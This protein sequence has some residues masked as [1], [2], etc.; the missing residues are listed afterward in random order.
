MDSPRPQAPWL[1]G[2]CLCAFAVL[3]TVLPTPSV[4]PVSMPLVLLPLL[5]LIRLLPMALAVPWVLGIS[6]VLWFQLGQTPVV[7]FVLLQLLLLAD[8][9]AAQFVRRD[10]LLLMDL[11]AALALSVGCLLYTSPSP[12]DGLLSRMPSS[13]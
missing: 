9:V 6:A 13:A 2:S 10:N 8:V 3:L 12:R 11:T 7:W 4:G 5:L 1:V